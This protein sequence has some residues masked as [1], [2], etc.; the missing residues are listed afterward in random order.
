[1]DD[2]KRKIDSLRAELDD[3][4]VFKEI[5]KY[6][7]DFTKVDLFARSRWSQIFMSNI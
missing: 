3:P 7:Y 2:L 4:A 1:M 6:S 5:Y